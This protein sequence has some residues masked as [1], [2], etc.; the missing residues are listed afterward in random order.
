MA[1]LAV[2]RT[3]PSSASRICWRTSSTLFA[4]QACRDTYCRRC[5]SWIET[6]IGLSSGPAMHDHASFIDQNGLY[7]HIRDGPEWNITWNQRFK[8]ETHDTMPEQLPLFEIRMRKRGRG[9]RRYLCTIEGHAVMQGFE[10]SRSAA[11]YQAHRA[12]FL[13]LL[14]SASRPHWLGFPGGNTSRQNRSSAE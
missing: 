3:F 13:M 8:V 5:F 7:T 14:A 12:L 2:N 11:K 9:C 1:R 4:T 6:A 10:G